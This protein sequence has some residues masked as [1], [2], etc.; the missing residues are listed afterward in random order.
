MYVSYNL[1]HT[2]IFGGHVAV[3]TEKEGFF[4]AEA[5]D[6]RSPGP[7]NTQPCLCHT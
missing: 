1:K 2:I 5:N 6:D 4:C 7:T 3:E